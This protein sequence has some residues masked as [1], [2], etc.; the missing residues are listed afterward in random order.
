[1]EIK[2]SF[3]FREKNLR[4]NKATS[5]Q[6]INIYQCWCRAYAV[7]ELWKHKCIIILH[8]YYT[9]KTT[10]TQVILD[11]FTI[12]VDYDYFYVNIIMSTE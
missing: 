11:N 6:M 7:R 4:H 2:G 8:E 3:N 9:P 12:F 5:L 1:M 10:E